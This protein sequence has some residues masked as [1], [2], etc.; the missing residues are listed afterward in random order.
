MLG[1]LC[2][3]FLQIYPRVLI[4]IY[5]QNFVSAQYPLN[6]WMEFDQILHIHWP[7]LDL[8]WVCYK[9]ILKIY[10]RVM[11]LDIVKILFPLNILWTNWSNLIKICMCIDLNQISVTIITRKFSQIYNTVMA[12]GYCQLFGSA[13]YL[14]NRLMEFNHV[15]LMHWCWSFLGSDSYVSIL[16][17]FKHSYRLGYC[18]NFISAQYFACKW[19]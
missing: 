1:L 9:S 11:A 6:K 15:L 2:V 18:Q 16:A 19:K 3:H 8:G 12:L 17:K 7:Q 13:Q 4:I 5:C 10:N 14:G